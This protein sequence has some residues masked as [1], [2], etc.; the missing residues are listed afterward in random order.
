MHK[1]LCPNWGQVNHQNGNGLDA[2]I[3]VELERP[4]DCV[5][6]FMTAHSGGAFPVPECFYRNP[7]PSANLNPTVK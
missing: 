2:R 7:F 1:H 4:S 5:H 3:S 6:R